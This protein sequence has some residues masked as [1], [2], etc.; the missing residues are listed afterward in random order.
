M[1]RGDIPVP[2]MRDFSNFRFV[3]LDYGP[4]MHPDALEH[5][6]EKLRQYPYNDP[7][8]QVPPTRLEKDLNQLMRK[9]Y[10]DV[11]KLRLSLQPYKT[12]FRELIQEEKHKRKIAEKVQATLRAELAKKTIVEQ[13]ATELDETAKVQKVTAVSSE[14]EGPPILVT[15]TESPEPLKESTLSVVS[16]GSVKPDDVKE[17]TPLELQLQKRNDGNSKKTVLIVD[18]NKLAE[19]KVLT[20]PSSAT[21]QRERQSTPTE[22]KPSKRR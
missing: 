14:N 7:P 8:I 9:R 4:R 6:P 2:S 18:I 10:T 12:Y 11:S 22:S 3:A 21:G 20:P 1:V 19:G 16:E 5:G 15:I 13:T 17:G